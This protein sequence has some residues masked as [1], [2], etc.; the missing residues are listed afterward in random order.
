MHVKPFV[1][2]RQGAT[3]AAPAV[4]WNSTELQL[5]PLITGADHGRAQTLLQVA[6]GRAEWPAV[7]P[8]RARWL[9]IE[10]KWATPTAV[11][12]MLIEASTPRAAPR[13]WLWLAPSARNQGLG[14]RAL[15]MLTQFAPRIQA[16]APLSTTARC[17]LLAN[18]ATLD[19]D[20]QWHWQP[21][22]TSAAAARPGGDGGDGGDGIAQAAAALPIPVDYAEQHQL[23]PVAEPLRLHYAGRDYVGRSLW[24]QHGTLQAWSRLR[25]A[26]AAANIALE[27]IS[28]FRSVAYQADIFRRKLARGLTL[29]DILKVNTA[30]GYSEHHSG[31][32]LD[33]GSP[34]CA[35]AEVEFETTPA[36]AWLQANAARFG[37]RL[38]YPRNN[39][40]GVVYEPWH[41]YWLG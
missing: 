24:L 8:Q 11:G 15:K 23:A 41:W 17:W 35:P 31:R 25:P 27:A 3:S 6:R 39:P 10:N 13:G 19:R 7:T 33:L 29:D 21:L 32:A 18:R 2:T 14:R 37:F 20:G 36:F 12:L 34:G 9:L 28:G 38:S 5:R 1:D 22:G 40:H 4:M 30:P 26:A 16:S